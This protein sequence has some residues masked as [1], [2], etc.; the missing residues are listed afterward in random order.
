M[1]APIRTRVLKGFDDPTFGPAEWDELSS[2]GDTVY[3]TWQWQR[4]WW[5]TWGDG[6]LLLIVAE[7]D[8]KIAA[9]A[10]LFARSGM[11]YFVG[12][13][14][15]SNYLDFI[16]DISDPHV[17]DAILERAR[18][19][20]PDFA[21]FQFYFVADSS[22]TAQR[23]HESAAR[24]NL[25]C[26]DEDETMLA[27]ILDI[28]GQPEVAL[29]IANHKRTQKYER[30]FR[31]DGTLEVHHYRDA[32]TILSYLPEFFEQ[33]R[34]RWA[35]VDNPS[36]FE[37]PQ[38]RALFEEF[39]H[40]AAN[41]GWLRFTRLEWNGRSIAFHY[42]ILYR[43][44]FFWGPA[45]F[46]L[47]VA[48]RSPGQVLIR[49][50]LLATIDEGARTFDFGTGS[51]EFKVRVTTH[52]NSVHDWGLYPAETRLRAADNGRAAAVFQTP[53]TNL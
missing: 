2:G 41:T 8:G 27:P 4:S 3:L 9:L 5:H 30:V 12:T 45:S 51:Q 43:G 34:A 39:T 28:A 47:D 16:G 48:R 7:R 18:R 53:E 23:L 42:G 1:T 25:C 32:K 24:L 40:C 38:T 50:L 13:G 36:R 26:Y 46:A 6:Q 17:L 15:E 21:G 52:M 37:Y 35:G 22:G 31:R 29:A 10:P 14:F 20:V 44:R 33:H 19:S 49:R 11:V